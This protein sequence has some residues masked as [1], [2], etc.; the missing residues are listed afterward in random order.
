MPEFF[1]EDGFQITDPR[2]GT[3]HIELDTGEAKPQLF[4]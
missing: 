4:L 2:S 1:P 3:S